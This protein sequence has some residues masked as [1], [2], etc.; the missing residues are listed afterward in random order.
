MARPA[1]HRARRPPP[2]ADPEP[3]AAAATPPRPGSASRRRARRVRVQSPSL[4]AA[5]RGAAPPTPPPQPPPDTPPVRWPLG[6]GDAGA[7]PASRPGPG[8]G[9][10][11]SVR[12]IAAALWRMQP[13]QAPPPPPGK[14]RR[15]AESSTKRPHTPDHCQQYKAV[16]Q[17]RAG[18]RTVNNVP[19]E[20]EAHSAVRQIEPEMA[21]KWSHQSRKAS[22][23]VDFDYTEHNLRDAGGEIYSLKEEL[24]V[25]QD[26]IHELEAECRST[27]KQLDHL[28]KNLAEEKASWKSRE[29][30]KVHHILDA[31]KE[32]LNRERK[33]RQ[34]ADMMNS[35]LL[36][37]LSEMKFAAKRYLQDYEKERKARMLME[38]VCDELAKEIAEDKAEV[39]AMR[40]ESMKIRG[41]LEEE[42][43]M[44][45]LAE[46]WR[47]ERVQMKL[48][49]AKLTLENKYSQ[50]NKLQDELEDLLCSQQGSNLEKR[51]LSEAERLREAICSTKINGVKEFSYKP[52]PPSEDIFAVFE[53]LKQREDTAEKVI[54]QCNGNRPKSCASKA[55]TVSP[56]A[57]MFLENQE[58]RYCNQSRTCNEEAEDDSGWETVSQ[59]EENGSSNSPGGSEP[60]VNGFCGANDA[61]VCG[62]D[63]DENCDNDQAHSEISEVCSTTTRRSRNKR[64]FAGLWRSANSVDQK[65]MGSNIVN[66]RLSNA[67][68]SNVTESPDLKDGE[69]Y[70]SPQS[71]GQWRPDLLNPDIVRAIK[72]CIEWPRGVQKHSFKPKL[73]ES[74]IDGSKV[75]LRQALKQKI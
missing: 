8:A 57:D 40:T 10:A 14:A 71:A 72:G 33:Q 44:L 67:R 62:T 66:G 5:R 53:E 3:Q 22:R 38:E 21:T 30:G 60:S 48:V 61:S 63:W 2:P 56:E 24:M 29:H 73:L 65:K 7:R 37:D 59:V 4:A 15:R 70:D 20:V 74:K 39:E 35:K 32:E 18:N 31:V 27:K 16:I 6:S 45:Q 13:L 11:L 68:M 50:L 9:A 43:K 12:E 23:G 69:V 47:E 41:E 36:N 19:H 34:R 75:Q 26:R 17:G 64:S 51:T 1:S 58:S 42:K 46:V 28:V 52:P 49:D 55:H 54:V 25:A